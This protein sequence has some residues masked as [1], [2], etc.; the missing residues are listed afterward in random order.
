MFEDPDMA[1]DEEDEKYSFFHPVPKVCFACLMTK[2]DDNIII[3]IEN[4]KGRC[5][6][7]F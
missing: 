4:N 1:V 5:G 2:V 3:A 7:T 6:R